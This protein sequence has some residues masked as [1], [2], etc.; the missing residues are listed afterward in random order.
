MII[1]NLKNSRK[2]RK[3]L[4]TGRVSLKYQL[5]LWYHSLQ[6]SRLLEV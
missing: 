1:L 5:L 4:H 3:V 6:R 2:E